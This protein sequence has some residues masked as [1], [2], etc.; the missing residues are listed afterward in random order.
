MKG[1]L[2]A[3]G[4]IENYYKLKQSVDKYDYIV[5][6]DGGLHHCMR[7]ERIPDII[8]GDLD[9]I[10]DR[11]LIFLEKNNIE[12]IQHPRMKDKTDTELALSH[13]V[14]KGFE[15]ISLI[16]VTGSRMDHTMANIFLLKKFNKEG[17]KIRVINDNNIIY[18]VNEYIR[19]EKRKNI[20]ISIIPLTETGSIVTL[21]GFLYPLDKEYIKFGSTLG[22]SNEITNKYGIIRIKK[23]DVLIMESKD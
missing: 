2:I 5:C 14:N 9:S 15:D 3:N 13:M 1:L 21:E 11:G 20:N 23:G 16:G 22:I 19:L 4:D 10:D 8:I 7:I 12:I 18:Y 17:V 6:V